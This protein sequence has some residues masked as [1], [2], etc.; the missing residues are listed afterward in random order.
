VLH[1]G[2]PGHFYCHTLI[3]IVENKEGF[4]GRH[5]SDMLKTTGAFNKCTK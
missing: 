3:S 4:V 1:S 5:V 2:D